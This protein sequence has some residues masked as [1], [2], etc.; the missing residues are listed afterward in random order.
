M[1]NKFKNS[2]GVGDIIQ[3]DIWTAV[4][5]RLNEST[6]DFFVFK[7]KHK[8]NLRSKCK[9]TFIDLKGSCNRSTYN[10]RILKVRADLCN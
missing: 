10:F 2:L 4:I 1:D 7:A 8:D 9:W 3:C 6:V 5:T